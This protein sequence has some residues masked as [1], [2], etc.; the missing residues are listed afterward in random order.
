MKISR[1]KLDVALARA[2]MNVSDLSRKGIGRSAIE[3][4]VASSGRGVTPKT[5]GKIARALGVDVTDL[6][7]SEDAHFASLNKDIIGYSGAGANFG[8]FV[9]ADDALDFA[10]ERCGVQVTNL[11]APELEDFLEMF[12]EWF[13]SCGWVKEVA[14]DDQRTA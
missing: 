3:R 11:D 7:E 10:M 12:E 1:A 6:L 8:I 2:C 9:A 13:F 14:T 4:A 5:V